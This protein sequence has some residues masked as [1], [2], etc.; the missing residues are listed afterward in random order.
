MVG[1]FPRGRS[2]GVITTV[3][4]D[5]YNTLYA[6]HRWFELEV[7]GLPVEVLRVIGARGLPC[8]PEREP[9]AAAAYRALRR[10]VEAR[11]REITA[12]AALA[13]V[14]AGVGVPAPDDLPEIV[15]G[16]MR[17]AYEPGREEPGAAECVRRLAAEGYRLGV[18]SNA[19]S[20]AFLRRSLG[21]TGIMEC[22][23]GVYASAEVGYYK[24]DPAFYRAA[25]AD[26][27]TTAAEAVHVGD[28]YRFDVRG[29][30][31]AGLRTVWYAPDG[32]REPGD[33]ADAVIRG[34]ADLPGV[35]RGLS[36]G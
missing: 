24:S 5:F 2:A 19:L 27:G 16:L 35:I 14:L 34:L 13:R 22:F 9:A 25:L 10:D 17:E 15:A 20:V 18:V 3:L 26:L 8:A 11:G 1:A 28:S 7:R 36:A 6:A 31:A 29:A 30:K 12:E 33:D 4:F 32:A 23:G 21:E